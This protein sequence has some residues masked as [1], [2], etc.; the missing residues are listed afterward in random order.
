M[1]FSIILHDYVDFSSTEWIMKIIQYLIAF[2]AVVLAEILSYHITMAALQ[3]GEKN[4]LHLFTN[5]F[6]HF[7]SLPWLYNWFNTFMPAWLSF[8]TASMPSY[9]QG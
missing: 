5:V 3:A 4:G 7:S 6:S 2:P 1:S 9:S 8:M